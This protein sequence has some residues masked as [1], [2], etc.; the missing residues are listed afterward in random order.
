MAKI[1][2]PQFV[3]V[4]LPV[5]VSLAE[6]AAARTETKVDDKLVEALKNPLIMAFL[7][8]MLS[9]DQPV[10]KTED[11]KVVEEHG[12][13]VRSLYACAESLMAA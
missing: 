10:P 8:A 1:L 12:A 9:G 4:V 5:L 11:E 13:A 3:S 2:T 7:V 6:A